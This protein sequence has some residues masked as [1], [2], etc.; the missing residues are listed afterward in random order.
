MFESAAAT[1]KDVL[2]G[3]AATARRWLVHHSQS[4]R[5]GVLQQGRETTEQGRVWSI[6][7]VTIEKIV[8]ISG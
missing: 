1:T 2:E 3:A 8:K 4:R 7:A 6:F 5:A